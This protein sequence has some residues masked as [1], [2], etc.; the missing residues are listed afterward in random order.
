MAIRRF[1]STF[2]A[3][4]WSLNQ[5]QHELPFDQ[6]TG[7]LRILQKAYSSN[8]NVFV[9]G[10]GRSQLVGKA[11]SMRLMHLGFRSYV[12]GETVT[13]AVEVRDV[14]LV[15]SKTLSGSS[16]LAAIRTAQ[17]HEAQIVVITTKHAHDLLQQATASIFIP[18]LKTRAVQLREAGLPLGTLFEVVTFVLLD[19]VVAELMQLLSISEAAMAT[20]HANIRE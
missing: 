19:C 12:I 20:R 5:I 16:V 15:I 8:Q 13:P 1:H 3:I 6:L 10:L 18:D 11:F 7:F 4:N 2:D 17:Q 9:Y 14:F